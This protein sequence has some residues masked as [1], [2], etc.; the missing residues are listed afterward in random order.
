MSNA[1]IYYK[2]DNMKLKPIGNNQT[3]LDT[4][5]AVILF[6]Y[7]TPVAVYSHGKYYRTDKYFSPTTSK[8]INKWIGDNPYVTIPQTQ[9][10]GYMI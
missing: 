9:I 6:S 7:E 1:F 10:E 4:G 3:E 8:H 5:K 2:G